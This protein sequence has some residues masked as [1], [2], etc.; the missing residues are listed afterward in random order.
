[1]AGARIDDRDIAR[2]TVGHVEAVALG[3]QQQGHR[4]R[5]DSDI[6]G[7]LPVGRV[8]GHHLVALAA[9]RV[10]NAVL[11]ALLVQAGHALIHGQHLTCRTVHRQVQQLVGGHLE[12][13]DDGQRA[14]IHH[15][16]LTDQV[17]DVQLAGRLIQRNAGGSE[18]QT[19]HHLLHLQRIGID[20]LQH[21]VAARLQAHARQIQ[22]VVRA[23][24]HHLAVL[25]HAI[26][27]LISG[28]GAL[29]CPGGLR[30]PGC[31]GSLGRCLAG[32]GI[33]RFIQRHRAHHGVAGHVENRQRAGTGIGDV[34]AVRGII[35][36]QPEAI[37]GQGNLALH[38]QRLRIEAQYLG[39]RRIRTE[40]TGRHHVDHVLAGRVG[41]FIQRRRQRLA[42][43]LYLACQRLDTADGR[44]GGILRGG[45]ARERGGNGQRNHGRN[46][47]CLHERTLW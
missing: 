32:N 18:A 27:V 33:R 6:A 46:P 43:D 28:L 37:D 17:G 14:G 44:V 34:Q 11:L 19:R 26:L 31:L 8:D 20:H 39:S 13:A 22:T 42:G 35:Q 23:V 41:H 4:L 24:Q 10:G 45:A 15:E 47:E 5:A 16:E 2:I 21:P 3:V 7:D 29:A 25:V 12:L 1:M 30:S 9:R 36:H 38:V 40:T